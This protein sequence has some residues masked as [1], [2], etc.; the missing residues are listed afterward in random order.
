[1]FANGMKMWEGNK[2]ITHYF[3][4]PEIIWNYGSSVSV[5]EVVTPY[6]KRKVDK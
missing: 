5:L 2:N 6:I 3:F 1:M 4:P